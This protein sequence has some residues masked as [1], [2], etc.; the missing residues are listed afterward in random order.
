MLTRIIFSSTLL[1]CW[2]AQDSS[3][4]VAQAWLLERNGIVNA[5]AIDS[6]GDVA[7]AG[8]RGGFLVTKRAG[9]DGRLLWEVVA[10]ESGGE[11]ILA[12]FDKSDDLIVSGRMANHF[13]TAKYRGL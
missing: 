1:L 5:L 10:G 4:M 2:L 6:S 11:A 8:A 13:Y 3:G 9:N 7:T 12:T